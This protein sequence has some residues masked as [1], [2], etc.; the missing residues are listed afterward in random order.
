MNISEYE[1]RNISFKANIDFLIG[2]NDWRKA[3][4]T[5]YYLYNKK[6]LGLVTLTTGQKVGVFDIAKLIGENRIRVNNYS[7]SLPEYIME[8]YNKNITLIHKNDITKNTKQLADDI[9]EITNYLNG[10]NVKT[11]LHFTPISNLDSILENGICSRAYCNSHNIKFQPTDENR[12][13]NLKHMISLSVSFP[14]YKML[15]MKQNQLNQRFIIIEIDSSIIKKCG[16][17]DRLFCD[18]NASKTMYK[19]E[20][21]PNLKHLKAMFPDENIRKT[22]ELPLYYTTDPQAEVLIRGPI[23]VEY[24]KKIHFENNKDFSYY[25][26]KYRSHLF[27]KDRK[28]FTYRKDYAYHQKN[29]I[30]MKE[31]KITWLED[32]PF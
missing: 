17:N 2:H 13:D 18:T 32:L 15:Y 31:D 5:K 9:V 26:E 23:P 30:I 28:F 14:N 22:R 19:K 11:F 12:V 20:I 8:L 27:D 3:F 16:I 24:I 1:L 21:G 29:E 7:N 4:I 10:R 25:F 6:V